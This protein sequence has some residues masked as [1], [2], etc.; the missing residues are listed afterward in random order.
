MRAREI[1]ADF[2]FG[3]QILD[4]ADDSRSDWIVAKNGKHVVN[5][6]LTALQNP[7]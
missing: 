7:H 3:E 4:I 1:R 5:K 2:T 6:E